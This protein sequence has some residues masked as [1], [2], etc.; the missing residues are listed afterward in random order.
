MLR[1][2]ASL[3]RSPAGRKVQQR[4]VDFLL[5]S[6]KSTTIVAV[7][8]LDDQTHLAERQQK[9]DAYLGDALHA[10]GIPLIRVPVY[11]P[12]P[13]EVRKIVLNQIEGLVALSL[14]ALAYE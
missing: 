5:V 14:D 4:H 2:P 8:E 7:I 10:A 11:R 13:D 6:K 12:G 9:K 1:V 3:W